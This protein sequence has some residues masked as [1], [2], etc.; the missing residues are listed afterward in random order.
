MLAEAETAIAEIDRELRSRDAYAVGEEGTF[1]V[2]AYGD[3][4]VRVL[5]DASDALRLTGVDA[6][7]AAYRILDHPSPPVGSGPWRVE[8]IDPGSSMQLLAFDDFHRGI[9]AT[10]R[11]EVRLIRSTAEAVEAVRSGA[12]HWLLQPFPAAGNLVAEGVADAPGV[13]WVEYARFGFYALHYN[14]RE[15]RLFEDPNLR[16]AMELC[17]DKDETVA[18]ATRRPGSADLLADQ[19]VDVGV[20]P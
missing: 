7:A 2:C 1:D 13:I 3:Y 8:S 11:L 6:I 14:L 10:A 15:G 17:I 20:R 18:A 4:L 5:T 19:P 9:P 12:I 16:E